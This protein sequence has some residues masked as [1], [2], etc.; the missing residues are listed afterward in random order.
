MKS[1]PDAVWNL[2]HQHLGKR[3]EV[4]DQLASTNNLALARSDDAGLDG[5]AILARRQTAGRGQYNRTW[6]APPDSSVL[7]SVVLFPPP[8]L[9]RPVLLTAWAAVAVCQLIETISG[10]KATIK[11]P[12][13]VFL[14]GKKVCGI[15][16][17]QRTAGRIDAAPRTV[18]GIGLNVTQSAED[19]VRAQLPLAGSLRS[20]TGLSLE[21][22]QVA[23]DLLRQLDADYDRLLGGA[24]AAIEALWQE[25]LGLLDALVEVELAQD[26]PTGRLREL[27]WDR[28]ALERSD[29]SLCTW[30]P[31]MVQHITVTTG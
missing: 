30:I 7:L 12:N 4:Y 10:H 6:T 24:Q 29:G 20:V 28:V 17:E 22:P 18:V 14:A 3:V 31:E 21:T 25:G 1:Y 5:L 26:R 2:P 19:F 23:Q 27:T 8:A 15:L 13:D 11:W 9:R 16:I